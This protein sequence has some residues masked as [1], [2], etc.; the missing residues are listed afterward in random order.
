VDKKIKKTSGILKAVHET[1]SDLHRIGFIDKRKMNKYD[2]LYIK[3]IPHYSPVQIKRIRLANHLSQSALASLLNTSL[4][5][6]RQWESGNKNP[7]GTSLKL[8]N[9][10]ERKGLE[11]FI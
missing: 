4:P 8:I 5:S 11:I 2:A 10:L 9:L 6:V 7:S 3:P 1:A